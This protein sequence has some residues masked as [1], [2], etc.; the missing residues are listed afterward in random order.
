[1]WAEKTVNDKIR[2]PTTP[3]NKHL[4][5]YFYYKN[6]NHPEKVES[7]TEIVE[8][9]KLPRSRDTVEM[10]NEDF[11]LLHPVTKNS[12][13]STEVVPVES[14]FSYFSAF[15]KFI[16]SFLSEEMVQRLLYLLLPEPG[17]F[18]TVV[19]TVFYRNLHNHTFKKKTKM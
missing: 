17:E 18:A 9:E 10:A 13:S 14:H 11:D 16:Q 7:D 3:A 6:F 12:K 4:F 5:S 2:V 15:T 8:I 1:V 19:L